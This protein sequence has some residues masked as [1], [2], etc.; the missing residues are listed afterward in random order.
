MSEWQGTRARRA[1]SSPVCSAL[2]SRPD[3]QGPSRPIVNSD[4][5]LDGVAHGRDAL[6]RGE[7]RHHVVPSARR[8]AFPGAV[9]RWTAARLVVVTAVVS[10]VAAALFVPRM[11]RG[12]MK[13]QRPQRRRP[14]SP[15]PWTRARTQLDDPYPSSSSSLASSSQIC[16]SFSAWKFLGRRELLFRFVPKLVPLF[17]Q[18]QYLGIELTEQLVLVGPLLCLIFDATRWRVCRLL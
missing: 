6:P 4:D 9:T 3:G 2:A 1:I 10:L 16:S 5:A 17:C 8:G 11:R 15:R 7:A 12:V 13:Q 18:P 14:R